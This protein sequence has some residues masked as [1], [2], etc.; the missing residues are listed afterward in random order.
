MLWACELWVW[1]KVFFIEFLQHLKQKFH[2][3]CTKDS[4]AEQKYTEEKKFW[5][6][7]KAI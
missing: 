1:V 5:T 6:D 4:L 2:C 7:L 3:I